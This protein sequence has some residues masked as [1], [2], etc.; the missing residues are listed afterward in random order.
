MELYLATP[1]G[2]EAAFELEVNGTKRK[3]R[4]QGVPRVE[5]FEVE[6]EKELAIKLGDDGVLNGVRVVLQD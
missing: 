6:I 2:S 4:L 1:Y 3:V 5:K